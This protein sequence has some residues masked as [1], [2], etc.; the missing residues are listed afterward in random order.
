MINELRDFK[1]EQASLTNELEQLKFKKSEYT[2]K[3]VHRKLQLESFI[4]FSLLESNKFLIIKCEAG[5]QQDK[6]SNCSQ[7]RE[8]DANHRRNELFNPIG[9]C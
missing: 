8:I 7:S 2:D 6:I 9:A 3:L 5:V 1:K 4:K